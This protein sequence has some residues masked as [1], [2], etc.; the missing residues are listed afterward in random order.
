ME[1]H[2]FFFPLTVRLP[3][4]YLSC[5]GSIDIWFSIRNEIDLIL[6]FG[7]VEKD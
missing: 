6:V 2:D 3:K 1:F 5:K 4:M 7:R